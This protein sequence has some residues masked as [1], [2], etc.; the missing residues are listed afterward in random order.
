MALYTFQFKRG[1]STSWAEQ[2]PVLRAGEPGF[3]TDTGK[4]KIGNGVDKWLDLDY[5]G[6][7]DLP[8]TLLENYATK[9]YTQDLFNSMT[10]LTDEEIFAICK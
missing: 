9:E 2:N 10:S 8:E 7:D 3:E 5:I 4:L 6:E 1:K